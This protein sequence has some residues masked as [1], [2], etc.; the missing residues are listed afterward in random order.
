MVVASGEYSVTLDEKGRLSIPAKFRDGIPENSL[1]LTKG[2]RRCIWAFTISQWE[3]FYGK[4]AD[5][6]TLSIEEADMLQ[7]R[8]LIPFETEL[9]KA[10]RIA[11]PQKLRD[12]AGLSKNCVVAGIN[13]RIELWDEEQYAAYEK[14]I[15]DQ[16][17]ELLKK[18][19]GDMRKL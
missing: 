2:I 5:I 11:V 8:F 1:I 14:M 19:P 9:D 4:F 16:M 10:G 6:S 15:D 17:S 7:H 18:M 12:F 13:S 3:G